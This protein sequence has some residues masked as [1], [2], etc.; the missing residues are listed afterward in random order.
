MITLWRVFKSGFRNT[1]RHA[2]LSSAATAIMAVTLLILTFFAFSIYFVQS[3]LKE[4]QQKIDLT[5]FVSD[6]AK[7]EQIKALQSK[8]LQVDGV[9]SVVYVSKADALKR[10]ENSSEEG[11]KLAKSANE[12]GNP[13]PA[14]LEVKLVKIDDIG[15]VNQKIRALSEGSIITETSFD[16]R[17]DNRK[18]VVENIIKISNGITRVGAV[19]SGV[20]L[21]I[22]LLIIFNTI[23][24][25]IFTRREEVEIMKLVGA[26]KWFVRGPFIVEGAMYGVFGATIAVIA[27]IPVGRAAAQFLSEKLN[28]GAAVTYFGSNFGLIILAIYGVGILIGALS[29]WLAIS[30]HL[31]V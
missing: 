19:L 10:L 12:I 11:K 20:F 31:K 9:S 15:A 6:D 7:D 8:V 14:S 30:R 22:S 23:R 18:G 5:L 21:V 25:A 16:S 3:Q 4:V 2:W 1:F 28:A 27:L 29:S 13:L 26:T 17:D 24:M